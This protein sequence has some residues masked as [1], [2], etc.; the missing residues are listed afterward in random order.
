MSVVGGPSPVS[1]TAP[2]L[3]DAEVDAAALRV[4]ELALSDVGGAIDLAERTAHAVQGE[5]PARVRLLAAHAH[6]LCYANRFDPAVALLDEARRLAERLGES[7]EIAP[8]WLTQVQPLARLGRLSDAADAARSARQLFAQSGQPDMSAKAGVNLGI[9]L[10]MLGK[11][12]EALACFDEAGA[13]LPDVPLARGMLHSNRA[14]ALLDLDRFSEARAAFESAL[15]LLAL[16]GHAH[17]AAV[18]E[19]NLAD[20]LCRIG[21]IDEAMPRFD[22]AVAGLE[23]AGAAADAARLLAEEADGLLAAGAFRKASRLFVRALPVLRGAGLLRESCRAAVGAGV[24]ALKLGD[25]SGAST[26]LSEGLELAQTCGAAPLLGECRL[27]LAEAAL[28][29]GDH[30]RAAMLAGDASRVEGLG[31]IFAMR[32]AATSAEI[33]LRAGRPGVA[34]K[35]IEPSL[36]AGASPSHTLAPR[37]WHLRARACAELGDRDGATQAY[38]RA[39][40]LAERRRS[41]I[42]AEQLRTAFLDSAERLYH[43]AF[44]Y[45]LDGIGAEP[46]AVE[47]AFGTAMLLKARTLHEHRESDSAV[48]PEGGSVS[49]VREAAGRLNVL[50]TRLGHDPKRAAGVDDALARE[51]A[52]LELRLDRMHDRRAWLGV[53]QTEARATSPLETVRAE[54]AEDQAVVAYASDGPG[55]SAIV[56]TNEG[57]AVRRG[58]AS[59]ADLAGL[60]RRLGFEV[61]RAHARVGVAARTALPLRKV[62]ETLLAPLR[63]VIGARTVY[64]VGSAGVHALPLGAAAAVFGGD[65]LGPLFMTPSALLRPGRTATPQGGTTVVIGVG[66]EI[67]PG[68][69]QEAVG[70]AHLRPGSVALLGNQASADAVLEA[71]PHASLV[72]FAGHGVFDPDFPMSSRLRLADRWVSAR[73]FRGRLRPGAVVVLSGCDTGRSAGSEDRYG[74]AR[75]LLGSGAACVVSSLWRLHDAFALRFFIEFHASLAAAGPLS[76]RTVAARLAAAQRREME[77][78]T[79]WAMWAGLFV[80]GVM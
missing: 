10:R 35:I 24:C 39:I 79:D 75:A 18:V 59:H 73:E 11:S 8:L 48:G 3:S 43:D 56:V 49:E 57:A 53:A 78:G 63:D 41:S 71:L 25:P 2:T 54:L 1:G 6:A 55:V 47:R 67:A 66:D 61:D 77:R 7:C 26:L 42:R 29:A 9:V 30:D 32:A 65:S 23:R 51:V 27:A 70:V 4:R 68:A 76:P 17:A 44:A 60:D 36:R 69:E 14:E 80:K 31:P 12:E 40:D 45:A 28:S 21:E 64:A 16:G 38:E 15:D 34:L 46:D 74:F 72:H 22:R 20:L 5:S 62:H 37:F 52:E 50:Y 33:E 58:L 13:L 19:G